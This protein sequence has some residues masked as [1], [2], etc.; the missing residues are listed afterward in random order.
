MNRRLVVPTNL[1]WGSWKDDPP[2]QGAD[3]EEVGLRAFRFLYRPSLG[4]LDLDDEDRFRVSVALLQLHYRND[5][6]MRERIEATI[7]LIKALSGNYAYSLA[8]AME[9]LESLGDGA[10]IPLIRWRDQVL[11]EQRAESAT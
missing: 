10:A 6:S 4:F 3:L 5:A 1:C 8:V 2:R 7:R 9:R 11:A